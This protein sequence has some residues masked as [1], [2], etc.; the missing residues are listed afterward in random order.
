MMATCAPDG[1][2]NLTYLS[3]LQYVDPAHVALSFQ[4]F[5]KTRANVLANPFSQVLVPHP[6]TAAM[7]RLDLRYLRTETRGALFEA[8]KAKLAGIASLTGMADVFALRGADVYRVLAVHAVTRGAPSR[9]TAPRCGRPL[10]ALRR[11]AVRVAAATDLNALLD[12]TLAAMHDAFGWEH[13]MILLLDRRADRLF[14]VASRGY[15]SSGAGS[16]VPM[17]AGLIGTCARERTAIRINHLSA[18]Y[19]YLRAVRES[20]ARAGQLDRLETEIALPGLPEAHSQLAVPIVAADSLFGVL[21]VESPLDRRFG[22]DDEDA[23]VALAAQLGATMPLLQSQ[24]VRELETAGSVRPRDERAPRA[25]APS[26]GDAASGASTGD[27]A[28]GASAGG[29]VPERSPGAG[30]IALRHYPHDDSVFLGDDYL[31]K[32]VAGQVL[33]LMAR[34][35]VEHG[36]TQF[37]NRELRLDPRLRLPDI[38]DNL[39][40]RLV[41]L[42][43]R[44]AD[45]CACLRLEKAGRGRLRL[46]VSRALRLVEVR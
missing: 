25:S 28:S 24:Q 11:A 44:L 5:N 31:I 9:T 40:A 14:T 27:A 17:G 33:W 42:Q 10:A 20:V 7:V 32:G 8:M 23:L 15:P 29:A 19:S 22:Y 37:T 45:R 12:E 41:L 2:P 26:A 30:P 34:D 3:Q 1:T 4:F 13:S 38:G 36:R 18:E 46:E 43:R 21:F 39:E 16:E 6:D 35:H